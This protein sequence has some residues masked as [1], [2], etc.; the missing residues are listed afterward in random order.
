MPPHCDTVDGPV[1]KAAKMALETGNAN[2]VL[3]WAY[4]KAEEEIKKAFDKTMKARKLGE[5]AAEV[6]DYW[7]FETV[8]RLHREGEGAPYTGLKPA[9][10]SVGP[11][12]PK[13][14]KAI[15]TGDARELIEFLQHAVKEE[16]ENKFKD[17]L[18]KKNYKEDDVNSARKYI[19][20]MLG[21]TLYSH[22][23][24]EYIRESGE[25]KS[26]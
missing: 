10:L 11:V 6:A 2:L 12:V 3:P 9:G 26:Q 5:E 1:V 18:I 17:V 20:A 24:H 7:F 4:K 23:L 16:I 15:E 21:F 13:V 22:H 8:V 14:E 25:H 19:Q